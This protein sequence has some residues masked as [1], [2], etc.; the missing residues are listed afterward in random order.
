MSILIIAEHNNLNL[1][2]F[3]LNTI[4]AASKINSD[5]DVLVAGNK[6]E[7][8]VKEVAAIPL[9]KKVLHCDSPNYTNFRFASKNY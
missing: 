4:A 7:N 8:V 1:K 3:T 5:I 2:A 9:V 6:C